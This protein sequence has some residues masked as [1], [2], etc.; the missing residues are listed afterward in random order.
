MDLIRHV[1][2]PAF[3]RPR[4]LPLAA[5]GA[6]AARIAVERF[7]R[8][9]HWTIAGSA[10]A[11]DVLVEIGVRTADLS[12]VADVLGGQLPAPSTRVAVADDGEV[13]ARLAAVPGLLEA[14]HG[15]RDHGDRDHSGRELELPMADRAEDRD[16][17]KLDVLRVPL[18]PALPHWPAGLRL[19]VTLQG[20]VIQRAGADVLGL[21]QGVT[22]F[23]LPG[24]RVAARRLDAA[25]HLIDVAG[26]HAMAAR[27]R[28]LRD[29]VLT[30]QWGFALA[31]DI[32]RAGARIER[33]RLLRA[34]LRGVGEVAGVDAAG[35]LR[36]WLAQAANPAGPTPPGPGAEEAVE[37]LPGLVT[38]TEIAVARLAVASMDLDLAELAVPTTA[39]RDG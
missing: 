27:C 3:A 14:D 25:A 18:G 24:E 30:G 36:R 20:D 6:T 34:G 22:S 1:R 39:A 31:H 12:H 23:W 4:L 7:V 8:D 37:R 11:A 10:A 26:W 15:D 29:R 2:G 5:P 13:T 21:A 9:R 33:S 17:L 28:L 35:R 19:D 16:G 38:G 32:A